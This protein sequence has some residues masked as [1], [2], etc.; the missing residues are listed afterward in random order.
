MALLFL[1]FVT[2]VIYY[3]SLIAL[4]AEYFPGS[5]TSSSPRF[6]IT[7]K[8]GGPVDRVDIY[9]G[10]VSRIK[11]GNLCRF[12]S[13]NGADTINVGTSYTIAIAVGVNSFT[14]ID[15]DIPSSAYPWMV[16]MYSV[17]RDAIFFTTSPPRDLVNCHRLI[18]T[19]SN[20]KSVKRR[21]LRSGLSC[22][23]CSRSD[24]PC[25]AGRDE[26]DRR[27]RVVAV[28]ARVNI[29][30]MCAIHQ[31]TMNLFLR[32]NGNHIFSGEM[33]KALGD[34]LDTDL[35]P[36]RNVFAEVNMK[37][38][39]DCFQEVTIANGVVRVTDRYRDSNVWG[40]EADDKFFTKKDRMAVI[41]PHLGM[42]TAYDACSLI[43]SALN[44]P[45]E[46]F[47]RDMCLLD[48]QFKPI[49]ARIMAVGAVFS[50]IHV[51]VVLGWKFP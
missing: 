25:I 20:C 11:L 18:T 45:G 19:C 33:M 13:F 7:L 16:E 46:I 23:S 22:S 2:R 31:Y 26:A 28:E 32:V 35:V 51:Q 10:E 48:K 41:S 3:D 40:F 5:T 30:T 34:F 47:Y 24:T 14:G 6:D 21:C 37:T 17:Q 29:D 1:P 50:P 39:S 43:D 42:A 38:Y 36:M 9:V 4:L 49:S 8:R 27:R 15:L 12:M 44:L